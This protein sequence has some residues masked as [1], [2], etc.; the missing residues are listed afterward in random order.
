MSTDQNFIGMVNGRLALA[1]TKLDGWR[2]FAVYM[3]DDE[4]QLWRDVATLCNRI[5]IADRADADQLEVM[6]LTERMYT[7]TDAAIAAGGN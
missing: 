6:Q 1:L 2:D 3:T 5:V 4:V 7:T